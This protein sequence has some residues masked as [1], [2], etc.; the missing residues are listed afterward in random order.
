M[1][2]DQKIQP[3]AWW[4][5][6]AVSLGTFMLLLDITIV[7][8]ALPDIQKALGAGFSDVQWTVD[9]YSL[10]LASLLLASGS[11]ADL[12]GRRIVFAAGLVVFT[13][14]SL[15]CGIAQSPVMLI[16]FR[17]LQGIG[18]ATIFSTSLALLAQTFHG[19]ARGVAF[20]VW[21]AVVSLS[22]A[23]GP[24]LGGLLTTGIG[25]R[26]I[27][28]VNVPIGV[29]AVLVTLRYVQESK[30]PQARRIDFAGFGVFTVGLLA[31]V[32][33]LIRANEHGWTNTVSIVAWVVA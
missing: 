26:W 30:P 16:A 18:G 22:T 25:W 29:L 4:T 28:F 15:L 33:G 1:D 19:K 8:V 7:V 11:V 10:S 3:H 5:L 31:L 17:A 2:E 21:G 23:A 24:L 32:Y 9:A 6:V 27:F 20:G 14:A 13:A 12:F